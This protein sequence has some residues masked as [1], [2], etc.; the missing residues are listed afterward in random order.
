MLPEGVGRGRLTTVDTARPVLARILVPDG[1]FAGPGDQRVALDELEQLVA[2][3][4]RQQLG[5]PGHVAAGRDDVAYEQ[6]VV[7]AQ[8]QARHEC[9]PDA[10]G[11]QPSNRTVST[12]ERGRAVRDTTLYAC[13]PGVR[14]STDGASHD[15]SARLSVSLPDRLERQA[16]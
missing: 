9:L 3:L 16:S 15:G 6:H 2:E 5:L 8:S 4:P 7:V 14:L 1:G 13:T 11:R 10:A 12:I